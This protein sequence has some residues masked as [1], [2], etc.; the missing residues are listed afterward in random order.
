ML[1]LELG[2]LLMQKHELQPWKRIATRSLL[3][4]PY[5]QIVED[6]VILP[7]GAQA[8]WWRFAAV[9]DLVCII[10][11]DRRERVLIAYQYNNGVQR[12]VDEF[13]GGGGEAD[14]SLLDAARRELWEETGVFA[15]QLQTIGSFLTNCRRSSERIQVFLATDLEESLRPNDTEEWVAY[16][17][18]PIPEVERRIAAGT[19]E[20]SVLLAAWSLFRATF[21]DGQLR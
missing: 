1:S 11:L 6:T 8:A 17:W 20:N 14:E 16:E 19:L 10:C 15:H 9:R 21:R 3:D 2:D 7:S 13:P 18:I 5:C 12:V 4:Q